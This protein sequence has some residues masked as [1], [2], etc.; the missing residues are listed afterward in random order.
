MAA[1]GDRPSESACPVRRLSRPGDGR[2]N[3][4]SIRVGHVQTP[5]PG[6][7]W[8]SLTGEREQP[9]CPAPCVRK[10]ALPPT[11]ARC[12]LHPSIRGH[13]SDSP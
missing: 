11:Q 8:Q 5:L 2:K 6:T 3:R 4:M 10:N 7:V 1:G 12:Q 9:G 13:A